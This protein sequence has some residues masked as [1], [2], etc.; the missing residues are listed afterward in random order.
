LR[1]ALGLPVV[2]TLHDSQRKAFM[3]F[4]PGESA[5]S[6]TPADSDPTEPPELFPREAPPEVPVILSGVACFHRR[7]VAESGTSDVWYS[8]EYAAYLRTLLETA[9]YGTTDWYLD[10]VQLGEPP[11]D[12]FG[13]L[14][15]L[16]S[17]PERRQN[18]WKVAS[19]VFRRRSD[20]A[21]P[22]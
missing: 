9:G 4:Q 20:D 10:E 17:D 7:R 22:G 6:V 3:V 12:I 19:E 16:A 18:L 8:Y 14:S 13:E 1:Y 15:I 21:S 11:A 2:V 5:P